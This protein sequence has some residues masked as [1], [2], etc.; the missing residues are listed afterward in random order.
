MHI[1]LDEIKNLINQLINSD[2]NLHLECDL[3]KQK[4]DG[5]P[6]LGERGLQSSF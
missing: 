3:R 1:E 4:K 5:R 2:P 6:R